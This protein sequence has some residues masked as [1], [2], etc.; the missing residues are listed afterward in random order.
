MGP[1]AAGKAAA[2]KQHHRAG[3]KHHSHSAGAPAHA[4][5]ETRATNADVGHGLASLERHGGQ[6]TA[7][8]RSG[9][10]SL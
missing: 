1:G 2:K 10:G 8:G 4:E 3:H 9:G 6:S 5:D 7:Q